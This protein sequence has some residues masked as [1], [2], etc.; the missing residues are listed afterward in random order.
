MTG[1]FYTHPWPFDY[2][3][4]IGFGWL[5]YVEIVTEQVVSVQVPINMHRATE[6]ARALASAADIHYRLDCAQQHGARVS[7]RPSRSRE[8]MH[9]NQRLK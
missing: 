9:P 4:R 5:G 8:G 3:K 1:V 2:G 6:E 7:F